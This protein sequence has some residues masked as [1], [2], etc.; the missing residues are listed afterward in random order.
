MRQWM[1]HLWMDDRGAIL[2]IEFLLFASVLV[3]GLVV[4][5]AALRNAIVTEFQELGNAILS[6]NNSFSVG[7]LSGA[8]ASVQGSQAIQTPNNLLPQFVSTAP[9]PSVIDVNVAP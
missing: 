4:G 2:S 8:G 5:L 1:I 9:I 3:I 7:G 6:I